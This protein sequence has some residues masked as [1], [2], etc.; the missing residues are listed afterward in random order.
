[1]GFC[2][3]LDEIVGLCFAFFTTD[4]L[5]DM[6]VFFDLALDAAHIGLGDERRDTDGV[7]IR[8]VQGQAA[9]EEIRGLDHVWRQVALAVGL[10]R[11]GGGQ[12]IA[13]P[14]HH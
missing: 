1:M 9:D 8:T 5:A 12:L 7:D 2:Q 11:Y 6:S 3:F 10:Q 14:R 13:Q 4:P